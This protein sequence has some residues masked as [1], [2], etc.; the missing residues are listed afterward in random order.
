[1]SMLSF[2]SLINKKTT[3]VV[4]VSWCSEILATKLLRKPYV[5]PFS[6]LW[7]LKPW[8][9]S[10]TLLQN[11]NEARKELTDAPHE[12]LHYENGNGRD[13]RLEILTKQS[14]KSS[15]CERASSTRGLL[16]SEVPLDFIRGSFCCLSDTTYDEETVA[17][18]TC[19]ETSPCKYRILS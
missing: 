1:M 16:T 2:I 7:S 8:K 15:Q 19:R 10:Q 12:C 14:V 3:W 13:K 5:N 6:L 17:F 11:N 9:N 18:L 4:H